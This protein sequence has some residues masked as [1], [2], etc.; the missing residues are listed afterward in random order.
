[1]HT[2]TAFFGRLSRHSRPSLLAL[3]GLWMGC[4]QIAGIREGTLAPDACKS[5]SDC[6]L[7]PT[8]A[9]GT[10][11]CENE[12]C[13]Y[14]DVPEGTPV[15]GVVQE[16]GDCREIQCDGK[17][18]S[19]TVAVA[20]D[21]Y[22]DGQACT[23]DECVGTEARNT[24]VSVAPCYTGPLDT[25]DF[26]NCK[27]GVQRCQNGQPVGACIGERTPKAE[28]CLTI[29]DD[30]CDG[31]VNEEGLG[32]VCVPGSLGT[33]YP[34]AQETL[35]YGA[36]ATG[37]QACNAL[38]TAYESCDGFVGPAPE[39]C[40][41]AL[42]DE[43]CD[44]RINEEGAQCVCGDGFVSDAET[45]DDGNMVD[46]DKCSNVCRIPGCGNGTIEAG[47]D[48]DDG[49]LDD[50][51]ACTSQC[52][53]AIC[54]DGFV[55]F[56]QEECDDGNKIDTDG[57]RNNCQIA[58]CGDEFISTTFEQC[59]DGNNSNLDDC[60]SCKK[61]TCGDGFIEVEVEQCDDAHAKNGCTDSCKSPSCEGISVDCGLTK[62]ENCCIQLVVAGESF[63]R[64]NDVNFPAFVSGFFLNKFEV[65]VGRF[66]KFLDA[67]PGSKPAIGA[68]AH[69]SIAES[70]WKSEWD[71]LLPANR[72][73]FESAF[74]NCPT[75]T[76]TNTP[77]ANENLPINCV[78]WYEAFAFCAWDGGRL[79]TEAEWSLAATG[80][81]LQRVYPWS[82]N[83]PP[84]LLDTTYANYD[85][86][87][88][89]I[90]S[91]DC[92]LA[93]I[94]PVGSKSPKGNGL[95]GHADLAG[96]MYEW[97]LDIY[98]TMLPMPCTDCAELK[99]VGERVLHGG[100]W[101]SMDSA[102]GND[103]RITRGTSKD[104][105]PDFGFRCALSL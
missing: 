71:L 22:D 76:W 66:R 59:D 43:D 68:G 104:H 73:T 6:A 40:D 85:C 56:G 99:A 30:D 105:Y 60:P 20:A 78:N 42:I 98:S 79:P 80:G 64:N 88:N 96:S 4:N 35:G 74:S 61:A 89:G 92:V 19:R 94:L 44:G 9:C 67:Y 39:T 26:G 47:E 51:D 14:N 90:I 21:V 83:V 10:S 24:P 2:R 33:C 81:E 75:R 91:P 93:D 46:N 7:R 103:Q 41:V 82:S 95:G 87:G 1:M 31:E 50:A 54:G 34:G 100:A 69:R 5:V 36:C 17:G 11:S 55:N 45:C 77:G 58:R 8:P 63:N 52:K 48:C 18:R 97:T 13:V 27:K 57:C 28:T 72:Q 38:G 102:L 16:P 15:P 65:T 53:N 29:F 3:F 84:A 49:N 32:C 62:K 25:L 70:G 86:D 23:L 101:S 37:Q 12:R